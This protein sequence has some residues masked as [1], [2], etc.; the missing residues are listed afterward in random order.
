MLKAAKAPI[1]VIG[2]GANRKVTSNMLTEFVEK[3]DMPFCSTQ[4]GKG[5]VTEANAHFFGVAAL[6]ANDYVHV[7]IEMSD[8]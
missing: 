3:Y 1:I 2:A 7:A 8:W 4:M 6:S 5:V